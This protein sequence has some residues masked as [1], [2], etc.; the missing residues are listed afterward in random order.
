MTNKTNTNE[1][2][3]KIDL[4]Q[5]VE[6]EL[7][8]EEVGIIRRALFEYLDKEKE[9]ASYYF[10][11]SQSNKEDEHYSRTYKYYAELFF[12]ADNLRESFQEQFSEKT[13]FSAYAVSSE[14]GKIDE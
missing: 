7:T 11:R 9:S 13:G 1:T 2:E 6:M 3:T 12:K 10:K 8:F 4:T 5:K 14:V